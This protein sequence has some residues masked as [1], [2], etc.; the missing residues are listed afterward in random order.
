MDKFDFPSSVLNS[1]DSER[2]ERLTN[3]EIKQLK[4]TDLGNLLR[5]HPKLENSLVLEVFLRLPPYQLHPFESHDL[6]VKK[7]LKGKELWVYTGQVNKA[8][9]RHGLGVLVNRDGSVYH[10]FFQDGDFGGF[11]RFINQK[12]VLYEGNWDAQ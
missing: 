7:G 1:V 6:V 8:R 11:G 3:E 12:G 10:G 2:V 4:G 9:H 5:E